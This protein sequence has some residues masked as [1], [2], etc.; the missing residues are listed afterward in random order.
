[1][2]I[3]NCAAP[4][5]STLPYFGSTLLWAQ[6]LAAG[7]ATWRRREHY[8]RRSQRNRT[9]IANGSGRQTLSVPL[10]GGK[11]QACPV[12][13]VEISYA[14]DWR[15]QHFLSLRAAYGSA[16]YWAE[17][18]DEL[19]ELYA[20]QPARLWDW[21]L[22]TVTLSASWLGVPP[23]VFAEADDW[24][25]ETDRAVVPL[26]PDARLAPYPQVF[27]ARLGWQSNLSVLDALLCH[28][29]AAAGYLAANLT[30]P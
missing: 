22:A 8:Q 4:K 19:A 13:E 10:R 6:I 7:G 25:P 23:L 29:P 21:N 2:T 9:A 11:H 12:T 20:T 30:N 18:A 24:H 15:R 5:R 3:D 28:G 26:G 16:P 1:M 14:E 27:E 17:M